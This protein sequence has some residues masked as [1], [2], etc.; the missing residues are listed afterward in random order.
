MPELSIT[1]DQRE[2][3]ETLRGELADEVG[4]YGHVRERDALQFLIDSYEGTLDGDGGPSG[5]NGADDDTADDDAGGD[6]DDADTDDDET[7][8]DADRLS[9]MM[10][11]LDEHEDKWR[12]SDGEDGAYEVDLPDGDTESVRTKDDVRAVLFKHY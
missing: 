7:D 6:A 8:D 3:L 11:L 1:E 5:A 2:Y 12:P 10:R 9:S 4:P